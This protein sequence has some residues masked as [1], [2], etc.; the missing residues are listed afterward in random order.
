MG[1]KPMSSGF[2][3]FS[4]ADQPNDGALLYFVHFQD[5]FTP[6]FGFDV[7]G[8]YDPATSHF[9]AKQDG[10]YSVLA[11]IAFS[12]DQ[13]LNPTNY[14]AI[15]FIFLNDEFLIA[16]DLEDVPAA[17]YNVTAFVS[18]SA[19]VQLNAGDSL[20]VR[21]GTAAQDTFEGVEGMI[22]GDPSFTHFEAAR[23]PSP[24]MNDR[25]ASPIAPAV[26]GTFSE[27]VLK[28]ILKR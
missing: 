4:T 10:V 17:L 28:K 27:T 21:F 11:Q 25:P 23:F 1:L 14:V 22:I 12:P 18:A 2:R 15:V 26:K 3:A 24:L 19:I 9:T 6:P 16:I 5:D 7:M 8:E 13:T 20:S